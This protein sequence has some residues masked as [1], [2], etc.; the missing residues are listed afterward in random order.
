MILG[1]SDFTNLAFTNTHWKGA[2]AKIGL[3][4]AKFLHSAQQEAQTAE[5]AG[6]DRM[7]DLQMKID[8]AQKKKQASEA[9]R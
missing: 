5:D 3:D 4:Y 7:V 9:Q 6:V 1:E 2:W 8:E